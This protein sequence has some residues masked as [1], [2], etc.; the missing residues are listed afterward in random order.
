[1]KIRDLLTP[2][3]KTGIMT[4]LD[5]LDSKRRR[6]VAK[7][8]N[9]PVRSATAQDFDLLAAPEPSPGGPEAFVSRLEGQGATSPEGEDA[10]TVREVMTTDV[11]SCRADRTLVAAA[12][13]MHWGDC[14]FLPV[15][16]D[17]GRPIGVITD[18]DICLIG[19]SD[20]RPLRSIL[21]SEAM[22]RAVATCRPEDSVHEALETMKRKRIRHLPVVDG[23]GRLVG[24]VSLTDVVLRIEEGEASVDA[25]IRRQVSE[26]LR[27]VSQRNRG[28]RVVRFNPFRED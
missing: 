12:A 2:K 21:V 18:G 22:S 1:M 23:Q 5:T 6:D 19:T 20:Q 13:A 16:D 26:A 28:T 9:D 15:V 4:S 17:D 24:V 10:P 27:A 25:P 3:G 8:M 11:R 7:G 14:R